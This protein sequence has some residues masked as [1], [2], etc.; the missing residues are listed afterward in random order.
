[1][2]RWPVHASS[3][4][5]QVMTAPHHMQ[6][7]GVER[8]RD[9]SC[10]GA[11]ASGRSQRTAAC[12]PEHQCARGR[13]GLSLFGF[14]FCSWCGPEQAPASWRVLSALSSRAQDEAP[15]NSP[16]GSKRARPPIGLG[17]RRPFQ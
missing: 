9:R 1:L 17:R 8:G 7:R 16:A 2:R 6:Q 4:H 15:S 10:S 5:G 11:A 14:S 3:S 13:R 12:R